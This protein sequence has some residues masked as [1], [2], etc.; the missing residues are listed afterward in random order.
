MN[1]AK[2]MDPTE[3]RLT[4]EPMSRMTAVWE[5]VNHNY[6]ARDEQLKACSQLSADQFRQTVGGSFPSVRDT[7]AHMVAVEW[8]W[9]ERWRGRSPTALIPA[10]EFP[11]LSELIVRWHSIEHDLRLFLSEIDDA[12]LLRLVPCTSTRGEKWEYS[13][14]RMVTH[15]LT[16]QAYHRG[17]VTSQL[18]TLG[19]EPARVD[20]LVGLDRGFRSGEEST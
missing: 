14:D 12:R 10:S 15:L 4:A 8:I 9:L 19:V 18:R 2:Q 16:H 17:Q 7:L 5:Q 13:L 6:W 1:L 3:G 20:F 11:T